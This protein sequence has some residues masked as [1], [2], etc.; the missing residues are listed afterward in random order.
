MLRKDAT[1]GMARRCWYLLS[2]LLKLYAE[3]A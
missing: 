3:I 2:Q 1:E